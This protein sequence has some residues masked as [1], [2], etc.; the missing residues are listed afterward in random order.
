MLPVA[1]TESYC[2]TLCWLTHCW[3]TPDFWKVKIQ[4]YSTLFWK[5]IY[6]AFLLGTC[7]YH[8]YWDLTWVLFQ[9]CCC[10][11]SLARFLDSHQML[12][13]TGHSSRRFW[14]WEELEFRCVI[15]LILCLRNDLSLLMIACN[16]VLSWS[17]FYFFRNWKHLE[18]DQWESDQVWLHWRKW[19]WLWWF[20]LILNSKQVRVKTF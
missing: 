20:W 18:D 16:L 19:T 1:F 13:Q 2:W 3:P 8:D 7:Q 12:E 9:S 14:C 15:L 4:L 11:Y 5:S 17:Q 10:F 6:D